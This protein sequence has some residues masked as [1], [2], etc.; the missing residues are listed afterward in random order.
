MKGVCAMNKVDMNM[1]IRL[2][3]IAITAYGVCMLALLWIII[4]IFDIDKKS[5][6]II[7]KFMMCCLLAG[8]LTSTFWLN[9]FE[10][11]NLQ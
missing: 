2:S 4:A 10:P 8:V 3:M 9:V 11:C 5:R 7:H 1:V 6:D